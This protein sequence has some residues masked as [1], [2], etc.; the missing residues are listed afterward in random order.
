MD[1]AGLPVTLLDTAGLRDTEDHVENL[2][3]ELAKKRAEAADLRVF[4]SD[5]PKQLGVAMQPEDIQVL[6]KADLRSDAAAAV[7]GKT[8]HGVDALVNRYRV[9]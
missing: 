2:G 7:S 5:A 1:L 4:L 8:G 9:Y 3:I 6:P